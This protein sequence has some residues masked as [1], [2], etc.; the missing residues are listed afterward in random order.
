MNGM[1]RYWIDEVL[2]GS[3]LAR[4]LGVTVCSVE[5]DR[6]ILHLP[7]KPANVTVDDVVHG[8]VIATLIDIAGAAASASGIRDS[9]ASGGATATISISY[10]AAAR[11]ADLT[12]EAVVIQRSRT[13][14]VSDVSVRDPSGVLVAKG[15]V[16][17]RIFLKK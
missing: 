2:A 8:G 7:F 11:S 5:Q 13:Q 14:T 1:A 4:H 9:E 15:M 12:A 16:T 10:L 17:S 6:V 3:P